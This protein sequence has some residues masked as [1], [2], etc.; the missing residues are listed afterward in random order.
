[1]LYTTGQTSMKNNNYIAKNIRPAEI[2]KFNTR[3]WLLG[4][5]YFESIFSYLDLTDRIDALIGTI[6][7]TVSMHF[8]EY[9]WN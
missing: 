2:S 4:S 9:E 3:M 5:K 1:M 7:P 6:T 8:E